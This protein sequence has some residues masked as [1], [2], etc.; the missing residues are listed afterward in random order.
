MGSI[1]EP[2]L[3]AIPTSLLRDKLNSLYSLPKFKRD[4]LRH[5]AHFDSLWDLKEMALIEGKQSIE[6]PEDWIDALDKLEQ[7]KD[8]VSHR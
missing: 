8:K 4:A 2:K 7:A 6:I 3:K 5:N 1:N